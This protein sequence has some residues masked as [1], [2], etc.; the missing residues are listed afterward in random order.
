M[1]DVAKYSIFLWLLVCIKESLW[2]TKFFLSEPS[3]F[4]QF[5]YYYNIARFLRL[6]SLIHEY[7]ISRWI[8]L[9]AFLQTIKTRR[10]RLHQ[11]KAWLTFLQQRDLFSFWRVKFSAELRS[12]FSPYLIIQSF[13]EEF[14]DQLS[15]MSEGMLSE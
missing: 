14:F 12:I 8:L 15:G 7:I 10:S 4:I 1:H 11:R 2:D 13:E 3:L 9:L 6:L 5:L